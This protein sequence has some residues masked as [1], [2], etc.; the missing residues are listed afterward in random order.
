MISA[1]SHWKRQR[2]SAVAL[3]PLTLWLVISVASLA[4]ADYSTVHLW[5]TAPINVSLLSLFVILSCYHAILG[6]E[7]VMED[8]INESSFT[9]AFGPARIVLLLIAAASLLAIIQ[10]NMGNS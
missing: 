4:A 6:I 9:K 10:I 2:L 5:L 1:S 3:I 8:Y 7:V